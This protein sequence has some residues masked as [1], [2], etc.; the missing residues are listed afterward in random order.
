M[1][2]GGGT[3]DTVANSYVGEVTILGTSAQN[4]FPTVR[5]NKAAGTTAI[6]GDLTINGGQVILQAP[7]QIADTANVVVNGDPTT[8]NPF[9]LQLNG[10]AETINNLTVNGGGVSTGVGALTANNITV[11]QGIASA[12]HIQINSGGGIVTANGLLT[13]G[14][15]G[16]ITLG[17]SNATLVVNGGLQM[18]G[19]NIT[20]NSGGGANI[21]RLNS[22]VTATSSVGQ[23]ALLGNSTDS[24]TFLELNGNLVFN[25]ADGPQGNDLAVGAVVINS[26]GVG[27]SPGGITKSGTGLM[28][29]QGGASGNSYT[30]P[31]VVS[32]GTL[33]LNKNGGVVAV[34]T[35]LTVGASGTPAI[36]RI[37]ANDQIANA[38]NVT[39]GANGTLDLQTFNTNETVASLSGSAGASVL[40]GPS[41]ALNVTIGTDAV[42]AGNIV[43]GGAENAVTKN[44][45]GKWT[46]SGVNEFVGN[47]VVSG[48]IVDVVGS[49]NGSTAL[50]SGGATLQGSGS[51]SDVF[52]AAGGTVS[53][54]SDVGKLDV[55]NIDLSLGTLSATI[56]GNTFGSTYDVIN[57]AGYRCFGRTAHS[58]RILCAKRDRQVLPD[59]E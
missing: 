46:L 19:G 44:G 45:G 23:S 2:I 6:T 5:L 57:A 26:T 10:Q 49:L 34:P 20:Q 40:L 32:A 58:I 43:G 16:R 30:G 54:G 21:V 25:V 17:A 39:L 53:G 59:R 3:G 8:S 55:R 48:G 9:S 33:D 37:R 36:V 27:A 50:V 13:V 14:D 24:D 38:A 12:D 51:V 11:N 18:T 42:F 52:A 28:V 15:F 47:L 29:L 35:D 22:G 4:N 1:N 31:T 56:S 7:N 41:S